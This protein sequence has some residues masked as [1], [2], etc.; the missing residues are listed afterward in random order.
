MAGANLHDQVSVLRSCEQCGTCSSACPLT[1]VEDFN[2]RRILRHVELGLGDEIAA[3]P[4]PWQCTTCG[5][6]ETACPNR[7]GIL[8]ILRPLRAMAAVTHRPVGPAPCVKACPAEIDVPGYLRLIAQGKAEEAHALILEKVPFPGILGRICTHPCE[9][10]CKRAEVNQA[11][12]ICHLKRYAADHAGEFPEKIRRVSPD[13]GRKVAVIGAGPAGLTAAFY[14]RKK[15][16]A[17]KVFEARGRAG[18]M[19]RYGVPGFRL[20]DAV[21]NQEIDQILRLGIEL[22][23]GKPLGRDGF[24]LDALKRDGHDAILV[25]TGLQASKRIALEG[26]ALDGVRWGLDFLVKVREGNAP[27]IA[28]KVVVIGGGDVAVDVA[29]TALRVGAAEVTMACL[30]RKDEMPAHAWEIDRAIEE[31][32]KLM[33]AWGPVRLTGENGRVRSLELVRCTSVFDADGNFKPTFGEETQ[34]VSA[35]HVILAVGQTAD[36]AFVEGN[37]SLEVKGD[38][39][40]I[41]EATLATSLDGVF[42]S[43]EAA[44]GPGSL[45]EAIAAGKRAA[46]SIDRFLGGDGVVDPPPEAPVGLHEY[47]G[48]R[49]RGFADRPRIDPPVL[50]LEERHTAFTEVEQGYAH[51]QAVAEASRCLDCDLERHPE[52]LKRYRKQAESEAERET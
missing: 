23:T 27:E 17:V 39:I 19:L 51:E 6:C 35:D 50:P 42:A 9:D 4:H 34:T 28:G 32:V 49:E 26:G 8:D 22:E 41:D 16:H 2:V 30:E 46:R 24:D 3:T 45:I 21:I 43:G 25:A 12:A 31:G 47:D 7:V 48:A 1:G 10:V 40:R 13:T 52:F 14:L 18:G 11:V 33:P 29:L 37:G 5:R 20:P 44:D 38:R 15:G 36:L